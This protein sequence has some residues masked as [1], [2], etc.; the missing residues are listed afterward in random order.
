MLLIYTHQITNRVKYTFNVIFNSILGIEYTITS[1]ADVF[2][3]LEGAKISYTEK[4]IGDEIFFESSGLLFETEINTSSRLTP[5]PSPMGEESKNEEDIFALTFFLVS[6]YEEYLPF[7]ADHYGRFSAKQSFAYKNNFI[8]KPV[9]NTWA[10]KIREMISA[11]YHGFIF[12]DKQYSYTPTIDIDNAYAYLGKSF[13]RTVGG[14]IKAI[15][16]SDWDDFS[17]RKKTLSGKEKDPYDTYDFQLELHQK[18]NLNPI[19]FFLLG[20]WAPNDKNLP[21]TSRMMQ[22]L[23]KFISEKA[24]TGMHPSFA[25]NQNPEKIKIEK[26]R[27]EKIIP[28][29]CPPPAGDRTA[30]TK[31]RQHFLMLK[32][33]QTYRN[34]LAAG[35]T[36]DYS[37]GFADEVGFRAGIC[38]PYKFYDIEKEEETNLT[39]HPFAVMD[40][41]LNNYLNLS[42]EKAIEKAKGII[43]EIKTVNGEFIS[44]WHN[45]ML[46]EW[47]EWKGWRYVYEE[48]I[49][50]AAL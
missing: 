29:P 50:E 30:V 41:S 38:T 4:Q 47:K 6:R 37:M 45:E 46:N 33:P 12:P 42:P 23:I 49:K 13:A 34:L 22:S 20:D 40:R 11:R 14:Y 3:K 43:K 5:S 2:Q 25:S 31:S 48:V 27:L 7:T 21:H 39:I 9:V 36:D 15:I 18:Y 8:H 26:N 35:I 19:Y 16:K 17:K 10:K 24:K 44:I 32:F 1:D 28:P